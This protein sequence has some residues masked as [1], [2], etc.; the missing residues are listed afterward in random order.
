MMRPE[1]GT[2]KPHGRKRLR[3]KE[4]RP[5]ACLGPGDDPGRIDGARIPSAKE[6]GVIPGQLTR[7]IS[8]HAPKALLDRD[9]GSLERARDRPGSAPPP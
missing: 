8:S 7:G 6:G 2:D 4:L 5:P 9:L 3:S 1:R